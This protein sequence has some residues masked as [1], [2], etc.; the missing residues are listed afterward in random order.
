MT[1]SGYAEG[2]K[3]VTATEGTFSSYAF[4]QDPAVVRANLNATPAPDGNT[5][6]ITALDTVLNLI[7]GREDPSRQVAV[8]FITDGRA[9]CGRRQR[10]LCCGGRTESDGE[11]GRGQ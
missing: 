3:Y 4:S 6:Y 8:I 10:D 2:S 11:S 5:D 7:E 1:F 9:H